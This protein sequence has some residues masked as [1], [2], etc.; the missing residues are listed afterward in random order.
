VF[1]PRESIRSLLTAARF[2]LPEEIIRRAE[3]LADYLPERISASSSAA[4]TTTTATTQDD[5]FDNDEE[6]GSDAQRSSQP[7]TYFPVNGRNHQQ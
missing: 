2:G 7:P 1:P 5:L 6:A 4:T 3:E